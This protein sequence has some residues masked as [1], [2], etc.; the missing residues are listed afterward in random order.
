A[1]TDKRSRSRVVCPIQANVSE[2]GMEVHPKLR[3]REGSGYRRDYVEGP[4]PQ[5]HSVRVTLLYRP[6]SHWAAPL[7]EGRSIRWMGFIFSFRSN[8]LYQREPPN[9]IG[10]RLGRLGGWV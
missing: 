2:A 10:P 1:V 3:R 4:R 9:P 7:D 8:C 6:K 5:Q